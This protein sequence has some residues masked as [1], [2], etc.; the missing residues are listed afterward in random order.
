MRALLILLLLLPG[1]PTRT[2][3]SIRD[4]G[5]LIGGKPTYAGRTWKGRKIEGLLLNAR[6]VQGIFDDANPETRDFWK[7]PDTGRWDP[8]RNTAE[9]IG[10]MADWR[11]HGLLGFTIN[12]QGG[13]PKTSTEGKQPWHNSALTAEGDLKPEYLSRLD[14]ILRRADELGMVAIVGIFYFG[15]DQRLKDEAAVIHAVDGVVD[16]LLDRG[17]ANVLLEIN[18]ECDILYD[19]EILKPARVDEL[20]TRAKS[21]RKEGR[22]LLVSTSFGGGRVPVDAVLKACDFVLL[23]GNGIREPGKL[24]ELVRKVRSSPAWHP[25]PVVFN[26]D[27]NLE[28][29][30]EKS[31]FLAAVGAYASWGL[32]DQGRND[33]KNGFQSPPVDWSIST[34]AKRSFFR[35]V[36]EVTGSE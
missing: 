23:H 9:F 5:F 34:D 4:E 22:R 8:D 3:V 31:T 19:H 14:R 11:A 33:Y 29:G 10:A 16:W 7:Y 1:V 21:R 6:V 28:M 13:M 32:Y 30:E 18:N 24:A 20:I 15:Q 2:E 26:E 25:M 35:T 12:L 36:K 17:T 27:P